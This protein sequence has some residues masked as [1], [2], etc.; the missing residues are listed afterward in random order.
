MPTRRINWKNISIIC[1]VIAAL[2]ITP[3]ILCQGTKY[4]AGKCAAEA[5]KCSHEVA[6]YV[7]SVAIYQ[8]AIQ[9][10]TYVRYFDKQ[11]SIL[12]YMSALNEVQTTPDQQRRAHHLASSIYRGR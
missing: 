1:G 3:A 11:D 9:D 8:N 2:G 10:K 12:R 6:F 7:D 5:I 4:V